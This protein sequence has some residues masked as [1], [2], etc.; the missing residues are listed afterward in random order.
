MD[1][2]KLTVKEISAG[3]RG[4]SFSAV[5]LTKAYFERI[6]K[7]DGKLEA[8]IRLTENQA[9]I[10]AK[11]ADE[12]LAQDSAQALTGVPVAVKD[13]F[14]TRGIP[15]TAASKILD[16][17]TPPFS[18]TAYEKLEQAGTV[19]LGKVNLDEF[20]CG[21]STETSAYKKTRNP[22]DTQ[23]V[24]GGS[25]GGSVAAVAAGLAP[26]ALGTDTGG[27]IRQPA[28]LCGV[29][30][31]KPTYGRVSRY[32]VIALASS[33]DHIGPIARTAE[34][35][36]IVLN[37]IAGKDPMDAT[38][39]DVRVEDYTQSLGQS[40]KGLR[41]GVPK[42]FFGDG[43]DPDVKTQVEAA[44]QQLQELGAKLVDIS[45]PYSQYGLAV[46][47]ILMPSELS[48]NLARYDGV[49]YGFRAKGKNLMET[50]T[51]TRAQGFG[52]EIR[53]RLMLGTYALSSG[54]YD[55]YYAQAQKVRTLV[56]Q[57]FEKSFESVDVIA[58]P[59]S[60]TVAFK[61]GEKIDDPLTMYLNDVYT[62]P[63]NI[64]GIP[65]ISIPCGFAKTGQA[66]GLPVGLQL[67][68]K[69]FGEATLLRVGHQYQ[70][71][72]DWHQRY[73]QFD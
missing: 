12:R 63:A 68:S 45:L 23:R 13:L 41:V 70:Q 62:V 5:E 69:A 60:P 7:H 50:Y 34:D 43:L 58:T 66:P 35:C 65:G 11:A 32:G 1:V 56:I 19:I 8:F 10:Q 49:R 9:A 64:A 29:T 40:I 71:V 27:S 21:T 31:L 14:C 55:A 4:R 3:L 51:Q 47:Y 30:G 37:A 57:D 44:I 36:A 26:F 39:A 42:E 15:T 59:T 18:A 2:A 38:T 17:Y 16:G 28:S 6:K 25:S 61:F 52:P 33:L 53:R 20:A 73:P 22:W 72:T 24:P 46:Y 48:A 54:Y 67:M